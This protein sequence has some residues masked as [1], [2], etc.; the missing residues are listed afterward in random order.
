MSTRNA[1]SAADLHM[2]GG[3]DSLSDSRDPSTYCHGT[4]PLGKKVWQ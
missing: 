2:R 4:A 1:G 3:V